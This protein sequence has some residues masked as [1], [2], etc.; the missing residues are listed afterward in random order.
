M[1][2]VPGM[3][4]TRCNQL[5]TD[6]GRCSKCGARLQTLQ[7]AKLRGWLALGAGAFLVV[8]MAA[9]WIWIDRLFASRGIAATDASAAQFLE[10]INVAFALVVL[11][12]I[13]GVVN[14]W[15]MAHSGRRN[16]PLIVSLIVA[17]AAAV[18]IAAGASSGYSAH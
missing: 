10:R 18:F 14:G 7:S 8:F 2:A 16:L 11:A 17:F 4:C 13:L 3:I 12:G 9:I 6:A 15:L 5:S 1:A